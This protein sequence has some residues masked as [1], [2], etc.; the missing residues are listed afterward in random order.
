MVILRVYV[1]L[2]EGI[3]TKNTKVPWNTIQGKTQV[4]N[5]YAGLNIPFNSGRIDIS[6]KLTQGYADVSQLFNQ[7]AMVILDIQWMWIYKYMY[8]IYIW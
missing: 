7:I 6:T 2:P 5:H 1:Y 4:W 3:F 8:Y